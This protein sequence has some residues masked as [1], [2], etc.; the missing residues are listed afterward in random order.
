MEAQRGLTGNQRP[1]CMVIFPAS[2]SL[3]S[4][5]SRAWQ[6][7]LVPRSPPTHH[8]VVRTTEHTRSPTAVPHVEG[9][10]GC[11]IRSAGWTRDSLGRRIFESSMSHLRLSP[12]GVTSDKLTIYQNGY[13][14]CRPSLW[15]GVEGMT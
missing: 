9:K 7:F 10:L 15:G 2:S 6:R 8:P 5:S 12:C 14:G 4:H 13:P 3:S 11:S 1:F